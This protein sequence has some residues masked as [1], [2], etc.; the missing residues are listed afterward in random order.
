M[1]VPIV[2]QVPA[3]HK[4]RERYQMRK[5]KPNKVTQKVWGEVHKLRHRIEFI[6][7]MWADVTDPERWQIIDSALESCEEELEGG[8]L[9]IADA[10]DQ[11]IYDLDRA[12]EANYPY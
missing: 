9:E 6:M 11:G 8:S 10:F 2:A 5:T 12:E 7:L 1:T 4:E 3:G